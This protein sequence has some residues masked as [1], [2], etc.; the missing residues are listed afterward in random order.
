LAERRP[1]SADNGSQ[2]LGD[3]PRQKARGDGQYQCPVSRIG[4]LVL[5]L[6]PERFHLRESLARRTDLEF[7]QSHSLENQSVGLTV[8]GG[9]QDCF[10][11]PVD[12]VRSY[13]LRKSIDGGLQRRRHRFN[14]FR[15]KRGVCKVPHIALVTIQ[16]AANAE[17]RS[18]KRSL[19]CFRYRNRRYR[20]CVVTIASDEICLLALDSVKTSAATSMKDTNATVSNAL[21]NSEVKFTAST[22][23]K[24]IREIKR[25]D[26]SRVPTNWEK[27]AI[28]SIALSFIT[29]TNVRPCKQQ[30]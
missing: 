22:H 27:V 20:D 12:M 9:S 2:Q 19:H 25:R 8:A 28:W 1:D 13:R 21:T 7:K 4:K 10:G 15:G 17:R 23:H 3:Q 14:L 26:A 6:T 30:A 29:A 24:A 11:Q 5:H 16:T 18:D